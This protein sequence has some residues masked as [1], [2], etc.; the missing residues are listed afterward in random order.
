MDQTHLLALRDPER[1]GRQLGL[2]LGIQSLVEV[3]LG[4]L[5]YHKH[6]CLANTILPLSSLL[7]LGGV[8]GGGQHQL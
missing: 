1:G 2:P 5:F 6:P 7:A 8:A 4:R 3:I